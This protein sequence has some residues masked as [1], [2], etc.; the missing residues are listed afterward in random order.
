MCAPLEM[1]IWDQAWRNSFRSSSAVMCLEVLR[2]PLF[3]G[4]KKTE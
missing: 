2:M 4:G 1:Y 3:P